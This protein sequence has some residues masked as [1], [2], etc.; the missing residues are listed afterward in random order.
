M[1]GRFRASLALLL[2][3]YFCDVHSQSYHSFQD[4]DYGEFGLVDEENHDQRCLLLKFHAKL[5][6][7]NL[8]GTSIETEVGNE[9]LIVM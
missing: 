4:A 9:N 5:Y 1:C 8:N 2:C 7:F 3:F 6:N